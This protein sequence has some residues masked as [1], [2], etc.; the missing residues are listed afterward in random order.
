MNFKIFISYSTHDLDQVNLLRQQLANTPV[1]IFVAEHSVLPSQ[2]LP[3]E[4]SKAIQDCDLFVVLWSENARDSDWVSQEIGRA[5]ALQKTILPLVLTEGLKLPGF[6]GN[7]KYIP[8]FSE[9][10]LALSQ[11]REIAISE[12]NKKATQQKEQEQKTTLFLMGVGALFLWA[13]NQK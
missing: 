8:V 7:L 12:Y 6:I 2:E 4:I 3:K 13:I 9:P 11:A 1:T 10:N 5:S